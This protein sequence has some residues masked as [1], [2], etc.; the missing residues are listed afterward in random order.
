[1]LQCW[2]QPAARKRKSTPTTLENVK[3][4]KAEY[5]KEKRA[6]S[7]NHYDPRPSSL[8]GTTSGEITALQENLEHLN[9]PVALLHVLKCV[10]SHPIPATTVTLLP[11]I[12]RSSLCKVT[13]SIEKLAKPLS[14]HTI[15][16]HGLHFVSMISHSQDDRKRIEVVT[17]RQS[18]CARWFEAF[19]ENN[20][21]TFWC[22]V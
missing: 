5:G 15:Y 19:W 10:I 18:K 9:K 12:P 2:H 6:L 3:F 22:P 13:T 7:S 4:L 21:L 11:P 8:Q 17:Q 1:M 16:N 20:F 14:L